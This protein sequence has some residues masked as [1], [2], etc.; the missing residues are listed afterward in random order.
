MEIEKIRQKLNAVLK[1]EFEVSTGRLGIPQPPFPENH[2]VDETSEFLKLNPNN[3]GTTT[4]MPFSMDS[5]RELENQLIKELSSWFGDSTADGY[6]S[7]GSTEGNIMGLWLA[8]EKLK[9]FGRPVVIAHSECHYSIDKACNLLNLPL[10]KSDKVRWKNPLDA[11][12]INILTTEIN[13]P[14][15]IVATIGHTVTGIIDDVQSISHFI[16]N[17]SLKC[18]LH[19]DAAVGGLFSTLLTKNNCDFITSDVKSITV[20][21]HKYGF[22]YY[23]SGIFLCRKDM[24]NLIAS[25]ADYISIFDDTLTGSR[26]GIIP[27][28]TW[29]NIMLIGKSGFKERMLAILQNKK[30]FIDSLEKKGIKYISQEH[31]PVVSIIIKNKLSLD[32]EKKYRMHHILRPEGFA[33]NIFFYPEYYS[34][35]SDLLSEI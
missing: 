3:I 16:N 15:I 7:S 26:T 23:P 24:Q 12:D 17:S 19:L 1:R 18:H 29:A 20:D 33:Y 6:M 32:L 14:L 8:R 35:Y 28:I 9:E 27:A 5:C 31:M 2:F 11:E 21:L 4:R 10:I 25:K 13:C 30:Q 22:S 34:S